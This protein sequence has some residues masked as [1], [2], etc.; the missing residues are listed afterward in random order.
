MALTE[1]NEIRILP[2]PLAKHLSVK[3]RRIH[4]KDLFATICGHL[5]IHDNVILFDCY[6]IPVLKV[7]LASWNTSMLGFLERTLHKNTQYNVREEMAKL[8]PKKRR[9]A[10]A[11]GEYTQKEK[12]S[13]HKHFQDVD[14][15]VQTTQ[16]TLTPRIQNT[17]SV[18][19]EIDP[20]PTPTLT[21][22]I[23][24]DRV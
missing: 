11:L 16:V 15:T 2:A 17:C 4:K 24:T 20:L 7:V 6:L 1:H 5:K 21:E 8:I 10:H 14:G 13:D 18:I 3:E 22:F 12:R 9:F 19:Q 23:D